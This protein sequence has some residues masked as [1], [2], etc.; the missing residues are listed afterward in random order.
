M[1]T[2]PS[3]AE[4]VPARDDLTIA[5]PSDHERVVTRIIDAPVAIVFAAWADPA[6][7]RQWWVPKSSGMAL[8]SCAMNVRTGGTYRLEFAHPDADQ[9]MAFFGSYTEVIPDMRIVWTN[10]ESAQGAVTTVTF[11]DD[12][13][14]T[15]LVIH[16]RYPSKTALD[17]EIASGATCGLRETLAQLGAMVK[18]MV[19][20]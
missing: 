4:P 17:D 10:E 20:G 18:A 19:P 11:A 3:G 9:P 8:L 16:D 1:M 2:E 6:L 14:K 7:F 12:D 15:K 5:H 13:G